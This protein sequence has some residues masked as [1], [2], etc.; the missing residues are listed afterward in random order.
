MT[1]TKVVLAVGLGL[2]ALLALTAVAS[3]K[4]SKGA[5]PDLVVTKVSKPP[6]SRTV[7]SKVK[8]VVTV[9]NKGS[10]AAGKSRL[11]VY[12][13]KGKK[14]KAK[15][16]RLKRVKVKPLAA[17]KKTKLK[18]N[19][20]LPAKTAAGSYRLIACAD[21]TKKLRESKEGNC[22]ASKKFKLQ[23]EPA[24]ATAAAPA[25]TMTDGIDW[26]FREN[27][28]GQ[29]PKAGDPI[30]ATLRVANG[31]PGQAGYTRSAVAPVGLL[32]GSSS[33][34]KFAGT[35]DS[36]VQ[37]SLPFAFPFGGINE[38]SVSVGTNGW[39]SFGDPAGDYW[40]DSQ[41]SDYRG[42]IAVVGNFDRGIMPYWDDL[43]LE[44]QGVAGPG[45]VKMVSAAGAVA[46]QWDL[47]QHAGDG[48][49]RRLFQL[50]LFP[51]GSFRFDYPGANVPG[52][53]K[54]FVG[55]SLGSGPASAD[56]VSAE[57]V[58]VPTT[59]LLF[60]PKALIPGQ[61]LAAGQ[62]SM[63]L[64]AGSAVI[65]ADPGCVL[66]QASGQFS[67]GLVSCAIPAL[68]PGEQLARNVTFST[69]PNAPGQTRPANFRFA[70]SYLSGGAVLRDE[71]EIRLFS[72][73]LNPTA[74]QL[75]ALY[76]APPAP[77]VGVQSRFV[78]QLLSNSGGLD[79]PTATFT[80]PANTKLDSIEIEGGQL[81]CDPPAGAQVTC[82]P[83][84]GISNEGIEIYVTPNAGAA[85][86]GMTLGVS[87]QALNAPKASDSVTSPNVA[88]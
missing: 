40:D 27:V 23:A 36:A 75:E 88:P 83:P 13:A 79:E 41:L 46:F 4:S 66:V 29:I 18:L 70:G 62:T 9:K 86:S 8:L 20:T 85:G 45:T 33:E 64:P 5:R 25:F 48:T 15:D 10:A 39:V 54:S 37:V 58:A 21:D 28:A 72:T 67:A 22:V 31:L 43:D 74:I 71:D 12:L 19:L 55:Y 38:T 65:S 24:A 1:R 47:G 3:A 57:G 11:G 76:I 63:T 73:S 84:S 61:A 32:A 6:A 49:P 51:D 30:T 35:D 2:V 26:G 68:N 34:L 77:E 87:M 59:S 42:V 44:D 82:R 81:D 14:H 60:A 56:V 52:G 78:V 17:G 16:K 80:L 53:D 7:G 69:P 50:V